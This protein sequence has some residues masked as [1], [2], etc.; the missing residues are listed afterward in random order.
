M[1]MKVVRS[2][3]TLVEE[4]S[5]ARAGRRLGIPETRLRHH[6]IALEE[7][8]GKR[9]LQRWSPPNEVETGR[10]ELTEEGRAFLPKAVEAVRAYDRLFDDAPSG[11]D[12]RERDQAV[13]SGLLELAIE[14]LKHDDLSAEDRKRLGSLLS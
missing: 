2:F 10:T 1:D 3:L 12:P 7:A 13:A 9:L 11:A 5:V 8:V 6:V 4:K 14:V